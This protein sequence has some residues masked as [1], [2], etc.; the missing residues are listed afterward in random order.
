M[1]GLARRL[2]AMEAAC[3]SAAGPH[4]QEGVQVCKKLQVSVT[5]FAGS[6]GFASLLRRALAL[7]RADNPSL[8]TVTVKLDGSLDGCEGLAVGEPEAVVALIAHL[9]GL[10]ETFVGEPSTRRLVRQA[11][12]DASLDS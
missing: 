4:V 11:W 7:A 1:R 10:L 2:L 12:P 9:L 3:L 6:D 5:R 8:Q